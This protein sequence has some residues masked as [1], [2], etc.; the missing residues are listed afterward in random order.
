MVCPEHDVAFSRFSKLRAT[1]NRD[2]L[3]LPTRHC[4]RA[5]RI[6]ADAFNVFGGDLRESDHL[7]Y[8]EA[9][10][11]P[12]V[13][14]RLLEDTMVGWVPPCHGELRSSCEN[15]AIWSG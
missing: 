6:E 4:E 5:S 3:S 1:S 14:S 2:G 13:S 15:Y 8:C 10:A 11:A 12:D 7:S 9:N